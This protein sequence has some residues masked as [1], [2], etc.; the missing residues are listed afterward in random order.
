MTKTYWKN[1]AELLVDPAAAPARRADEFGSDVS[2][3]I[4]ELRTKHGLTNVSC[5]S[6]GNTPAE[7]DRMRAELHEALPGVNR[8]GFL[9]LTGAAAVFT[10]AACGKKKPDTFVPWAEQPEGTTIGNAVYYS[11]TLRDSG[12]PVG[13]MVKTYDGRPIKIEGNPD[14][15][16]T[17]G[18]RCDTQT[19]AALLNLYDPDR[20]QDGPR[21]RAGDDFKS[22]TWDDL[23]AAVGSALKQGTVALLTG[24]LDGPSHLALVADLTKAF[25][26][27]FVHAVHQA[28]P[29]AGEA[30]ARTLSFGEA[31]LPSYRPESADLMVSFGDFLGGGTTGLAEQIGFGDLRRLKGA[32]TDATSGQV[33]VFEPTLSQ[34]GAC[35]D[36][37]VRVAPDQL[38]L[39]AW[40]LAELV[41]RD[42]GA[43]LPSQAVKALANAGGAA[44]L[45]LKPIANAD[46]ASPLEYAAMRLVAAK[47][48]GRHSLIYS[49]GASQC[50]ADSVS[51]HLATAFL[52]A[53]LGNDGVT[54]IASPAGR[55]LVDNGEAQALIERCAQGAVD[56][57]II[58][59]ANPAYT[60]PASVA[61]L[62]QVK[63]LV[64]LADRIDETAHLAHFVV[65]TLHGLESWGD[66]EAR[67]GIYSLQQPCIPPL[68]DCRAAEE[69]LMAFAVAAGADAFRVEATKPVASWVS[70]VSR[71]PLWQATAH[72]VRSWRDH[73]RTQWTGAVRKAAGAVADE[74]AF[75]NAALA[76]GALVVP[77]QTKPANYSLSSQAQISF[78]APASGPRLILS[79]S[80]TMRDGAWLNNAWLQ[81]LPDPVSKITWDGYLAISPVDAHA[82]GI[83]S[84][85][86]VSLTVNGKPAID[87]PVRVQEGNHP[88]TMELFL[89]WGRARAG[90]VADL[91]AEN[92]GYRVNGFE[93]VDQRPLPAALDATIAKTGARYQLA[94]TQGHDYME[95][96]PIALDEVLDQ[97]LTA[98]PEHAP[99]K[100]GT[101]GEAGG[102]ISMWGTHHVYPG[103]RWGMTVDMNTC[104]GCNACVVACNAENNVPVVGRDEIRNSREMHWIRIDRY[105]TGTFDRD[106]RGPVAVKAK[107]AES[108]LDVEVV[109]QPVMCQQCENAP[110]EPVCPANATM[111]NDEGIS[112]QIYNRCVGTRYCANNCPYKVRR[113]NWYEYSKYR[114]GPIGS[115]SPVTRI[116]TNVTTSGATSSQAELAHMPL[117]L[118]L[119]PEVTVRSRG[120]MEKCN[121]CIQRT[122]TI[123]DREKSENRRI[124]DG[125]VKTACAQTCPTRALV[126]GDLSD[127]ASEVVTTAARTGTAYRLLDK[128]LNTRPSVA[129]LKRVRNR[130]PTADEASGHAGS[131]DGAPAHQSAEKENGG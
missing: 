121:F 37:R 129:Y 69:S 85:D 105:F 131:P 1:A 97:R 41:A 63:T 117:M 125:E 26:G 87:V 124:P 93:L 76:K 28:Y 4:S 110:C 98:A 89:G 111:H 86:V 46:P 70:V 7:L 114:A 16:L 2:L 104:I 92:G 50:G 61:A 102:N 14:H 42:V 84:D 68:W 78:P 30:A 91:T 77:V 21:S 49:G 51:L 79:A 109:N 127:P 72:G 12:Q 25:P 32:A 5:E 126:F 54:V 96:R 62:K 99:W 122:R 108:L 11:S 88:G 128:E 19:Q 17:G 82:A 53:I 34:T 75:W 44:Q 67:P 101:D 73:V 64:V 20:L 130:P 8:R 24:P 15:P 83:V 119:N 35:S 103:H 13:V 18:G 80:R 22:I 118:M 112:L 59:G 115:G 60:W 106:A 45:G 43:T 39:A 55:A 3:A 36:V 38:A 29:R 94:T 57:L 113:F 27:R 56:T 90:R 31:G 33:I 40:S 71:R 58:S 23:D 48:A 9:R 95:G 107:T 123:R 116:V 81:E 65:P 52:N 120:V 100:N 10:L 6:E 47:N 74:R 66:A